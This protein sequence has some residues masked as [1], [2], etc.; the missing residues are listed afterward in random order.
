MT[1]DGGGWIVIQKRIDGSV[2]FNRNWKSYK[3]GFGDANGEYWIGNEFI[4]QFTNNGSTEMIAEAKAF[5]DERIAVKFK[6]FRVS[7]EKS[8]YRLDYDACVEM[9]SHDGCS[10]WMSRSKGMMFSTIDE[11]NDIKPNTMTHCASLYSSGW[12]FGNCF[13]V[14]FNGIYSSVEKTDGWEYIHCE[15]FRSGFNSLKET[16]MLMRKTQ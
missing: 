4:H 10:D 7:D 2:D 3:E 14:N 8:N 12:W 6:N 5:N 13:H 16:R 1:T 11:D 15:E 9:T